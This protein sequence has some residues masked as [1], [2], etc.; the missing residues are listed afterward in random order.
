[1]T[2]VRYKRD[3]TLDFLPDPSI[4]PKT[5]LFVASYDGGAPHQLTKTTFDV[6]SVV[7]SSD[8]RTIF[9]TGD[10]HQDDN[11]VGRDAQTAIYAVSRDGGEPRK[12]TT[13]GS[14]AQ[15]AVSPD[16]M[17]LAFLYTPKQ[18]EETDLMV[19]E[20]GP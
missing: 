9:F 19:A 11:I 6:G 1:I 20:I 18:G 10:E 13:T 12:L 17:R 8:D 16:G 14:H 3:G 4:H 2:S 7:W 15:L 5:Q